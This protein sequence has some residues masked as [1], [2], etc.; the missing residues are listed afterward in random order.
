[1]GG[2]RPDQYQIDPG[3]GQATDYKFTRRPADGLEHTTPDEGGQPIKPT[4]PSPDANNPVVG[5]KKKDGA[6]D[7]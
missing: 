6:A 5:G 7:E 4:V 2:K 1:M 3:E